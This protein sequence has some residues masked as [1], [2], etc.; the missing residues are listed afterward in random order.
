MSDGSNPQPDAGR[1]RP[2]PTEIRQLGAERRVIIQWS[3]GESTGYSMEFLRVFCPCADCRGHVP[4]QRKLI[5]GK[6]EVT[7]TGITPVG[8]YAVKF[9]F[10]D[11]HDSGVYSWDTLYTLGLHQE[12]YWDEYLQELQQAGKRRRQSVFMIKPVAS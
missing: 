5:D 4:S 7:V 1:P 12:R 9:A 3:S 2:V 6:L 11:G 10:D 8:R